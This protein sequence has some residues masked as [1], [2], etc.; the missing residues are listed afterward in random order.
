MPVISWSVRAWAI[1]Q[2]HTDVVRAYL[3]VRRGG[4]LVVARGYETEQIVHSCHPF[5]SE[6]RWE[7]VSHV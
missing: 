2:R 6:R 5:S 7:R 1:C 4:H 3:H